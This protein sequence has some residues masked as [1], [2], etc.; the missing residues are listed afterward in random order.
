MSILT[1]FN[2]FLETIINLWSRFLW[3]FLKTEGKKKEDTYISNS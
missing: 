2:I 3:D 1:N